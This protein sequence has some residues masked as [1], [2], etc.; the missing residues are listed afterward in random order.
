[1]NKHGQG[2]AFLACP[3][4]AMHPGRRGA[5]VGSVRYAWLGII[6]VSL[7]PAAIAGFFANPL[8]FMLLGSETWHE[9]VARLHPYR[10]W[11]ALSI[12]VCA[13][14]TAVYTVRYG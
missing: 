3:S 7:V 4:S 9:R 1:M 5:T 2:R 6:A 12:G 11:F 10:W 8:V 13:F 14:A